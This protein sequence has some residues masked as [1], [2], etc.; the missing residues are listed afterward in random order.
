MRCEGCGIAVCDSCRE[1]M[2]AVDTCTHEPIA[3][4]VN[5]LRQ[6]MGPIS[7][8]SP[9][10]Q[11]VGCPPERCRDCHVTVGGRHHVGCAEEI[12]PHC[13]EQA[14]GCEALANTPQGG[15]AW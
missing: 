7:Y 15:A 2:N 4:I 5:S 10:E 9:R 3:V 1:H 6:T 8:G 14:I 12:C 13:L 11:W